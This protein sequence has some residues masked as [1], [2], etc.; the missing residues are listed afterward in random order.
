LAEPDSAQR[1]ARWRERGF[2]E[3]DARD[4]VLFVGEE[5]PD[6]AARLAE[7]RAL[8]EHV[9]AALEEG[10]GAGR[11]VSLV[12]LAELLSPRAPESKLLSELLADTALT[13]D[14]PNS[15]AI[16]HH[17]VAGK[18]A[19]LARRMPPQLLRDAAAAAADPPPDTRRG[20]RR[21]HF[22]KLLLGLF[23]AAKP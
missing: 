15:E 19:Q 22:E 21:L 3:E 13:L 8:R 14:A 1:R 11:V 17:A 18:L 16:R 2:S 10:L 7:G 5:E 6:P 12:L 9:L 23:S 20:N 4:L